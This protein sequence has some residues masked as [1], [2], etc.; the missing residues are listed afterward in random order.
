MFLPFHSTNIFGRLISLLHLKGIEYD[1]VR[2]YAKT[3]S[4]IRLQT[5]VSKCF[6]ANHSLLSSLHHHVDYLLKV[7]YTIFLHQ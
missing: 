7:H 2:P 3:E 5:I 4:P 6:S 1:W